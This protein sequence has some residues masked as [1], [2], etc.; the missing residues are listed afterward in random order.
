MESIFRLSVIINMIDNLT[1]PMSGVGN[2]IQKLN[3]GFGSM[4]K[5]GIS[6][7][8]IGDNIQNYMMQPIEATFDT[9]RALG[10][11]SSLGIQDLGAL[12]KSAKQFSDTWAGTSKS[13]FLTAA[14]DIKSGIAS[15]SDEGVAQYTEMAGLTAK[16]TKSTTAEMTSLFASGYGIYKDYYSELSDMEFAEVFSAGISKSVQQFKTSGSGMAQSIQTLGATATTAQ[17]PLEEQLSVLGML[18]ATM[19]GSEA[20]TKYKAFLNAAAGA[21][22]K[23]GISFTDANNQLLSLPEIIDKLK[24]K[25]G[26]T[27]DAAEKMKLKEAFGTDEAVALIDLMYNKTGDLQSNITMLYDEMGKGAGVATDMANAINSTPGEQ[28]EVV[29]QQ[30]HN[31]VE[32]IGNQLLPTFTQMLSKGSEI[33]SK[34][35]QWIEK[36]QGLVRVI[37][38]ILL[39]LGSLLVAV[40]SAITVIGG[41]GLVLTKTA[42]Y[43]VKLYT[44]IKKLP[45][46]FSAMRTKAINAGNGLK[47]A[48]TAMKNGA[49]TAVRAVKNVSLSVLN[50]AK[51]AAI[52]GATAVKSF[53]I[54]MASM[55]KQAITTAVSAM[56]GLIASVWSFT[57]ALLANPITWVVVGIVALIAALVLLWQNW[58]SVVAFIKGLW[59][60]FVNGIIN[61]FNWIIDK[62]TNMPA[63]FQVLL[64]AIFPI[65][66]V[67][68]LIYNNWES[69]VAFFTNVFNGAKT[70]VTNG[71]NNI[72]SF[73][74][75]VPAWFR[76]SGAK[77][78]T[79]FVEGIKSMINKPA[80]IVK[81]GLAKVR[82]LLPF[83]DA[84]EGPLST[85]TLSG[86]RVFETINTGMQKTKDLP[87]QTTE[88]AFKRINLNPISDEMETI[89]VMKQQEN[90][91]AQS[92]ILE[93]S[94]GD[95][96]VQTLPEEIKRQDVNEVKNVITKEETSTN[97]ENT[98]ERK[99]IINMNFDFSKIKSLEQ[100]LKLA[101]EIEQYANGNKNNDQEDENTEFVFDL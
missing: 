69:I 49:A 47:T 79:T 85:L 68:L 52:N 16:A 42:G 32:E 71:I 26:E 50:F 36:N 91:Q 22:D 80:E 98:T 1:S 59:D 53:V 21:G 31:V 73:I 18:Q 92:A 60:G 29:K 7:K 45:A 23:L 76:Q 58:D 34:V 93:F 54:S 25:F 48:F 101:K 3:Q 75:G 30:L 38:T 40:G 83:S 37:G 70:A 64:A 77:I 39:I 9:Q 33:L 95:N 6:M 87:A 84:K 89:N 62:I 14:Y 17:V 86:R 10:E 46:A 88:K 28:Y 57:S 12:E 27:M 44:S 100:L 41:F 99:T 74:S 24:G 96:I 56:P 63:G 43:G 82:K 81:Q 4:V 67:P 72:K 55:A 51:T 61:G 8:S 94:E 35:S 90:I 13:D 65:I 97:T 66:G 19:S 15:L 11:L 5:T 20:G 78:I 2:G